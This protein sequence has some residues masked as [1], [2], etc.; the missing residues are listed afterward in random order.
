MSKRSAR[1]KTSEIKELIVELSSANKSIDSLI[2]QFFLK[3]EK[4]NPSFVRNLDLLSFVKKLASVTL[5]YLQEF[6]AS[7]IIDD[8][9]IP[10]TLARGIFE[11]HLILLEATTSLD[12]FRKVLIKT[13]DAYEKFT[14]TII[15]ICVQRNDQAGVMCF[16]R[17]LE[18]IAFLRRKHGRLINAD[19]GGNLKPEPY[20]NFRKLAEAH[21]LESYYNIEYTLL[22]FFIH[23]SLL[24]ILTTESI[25]KTLTEEQKKNANATVMQRKKLIKNFAENLVLIIAPKTIYKIKEVI[26]KNHPFK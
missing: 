21:G 7:H 12:S 11:L 19:L 20:F 14:E 15:D 24:S 6:L 13:D 5:S 9:T 8:P 25:D 17:E 3:L 10:A 23:P 16:L 22:S 18:R 2:D 26:S 4:D 1:D